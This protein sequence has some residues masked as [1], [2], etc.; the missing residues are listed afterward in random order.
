MAQFGCGDELSSAHSFQ[1]DATARV[2]VLHFKKET[3]IASNVEIRYR[4]LK[5]IVCM[6]TMRLNSGIEARL[7][8]RVV[9][10]G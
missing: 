5:Y 6:Y 1:I 4:L 10:N 9:I 2:D 7:V 3:D 8:F